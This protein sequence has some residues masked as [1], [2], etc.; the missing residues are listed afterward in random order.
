MLREAVS[1]R[2]PNGVLLSGIIDLQKTAVCFLNGLTDDQAML[3]RKK[4]IFLTRVARLK[5]EATGTSDEV[6]ARDT[7]EDMQTDFKRAQKDL[8]AASKAALKKGQAADPPLTESAFWFADS[9]L[10][11]VDEAKER[12]SSGS[13]QDLD[14]L[15]AAPDKIETLYDKL[16]SGQHWFDTFPAQVV[17]E[18]LQVR[19]EEFIPASA[20]GQ[21]PILTYDV[22]EIVEAHTKPADRRDL[23]FPHIYATDRRWVPGAPHFAVASRGRRTDQAKLLPASRRGL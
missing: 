3:L 16:R 14:A 10:G 2:F 17:C 21:G 9:G 13:G 4:S 11:S 12:L 19:I 15:V 8:A 5:S 23:P 6:A 1:D 7:A 20:A 18:I 22:P